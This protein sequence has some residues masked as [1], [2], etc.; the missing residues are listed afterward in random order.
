M[1]L[2]S[3]RI[4]PAFGLAIISIFPEGC[5]HVRCK[6]VPHHPIPFFIPNSLFIIPYS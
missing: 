4:L 5:T 3:S 6:H 1:V 2:V